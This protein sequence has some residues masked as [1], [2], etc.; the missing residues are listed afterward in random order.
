ML[1][2]YVIPDPVC[3]KLDACSANHCHNLVQLRGFNHGIS[4]L[5]EKMSTKSVFRAILI[6]NLN[7]NLSR[8]GSLSK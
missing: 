3:E 8:H 1:I 7:K 2:L 5:D 6:L 4:V